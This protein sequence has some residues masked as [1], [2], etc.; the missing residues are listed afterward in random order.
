MNQPKLAEKLAVEVKV[1]VKTA[2][3][4]IK[5]IRDAMTEALVNGENIEIR[6]FGT[7]KIRNRVSYIFKN[8]R[9]GHKSEIKPRKT[10][11]FT[12]GDELKL[13]AN[14]GGKKKK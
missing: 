14:D 3:S 13:A 9:T 12:V 5:T 8:P 6:R 7:F 4:I 2:L 1:P 11:L 10:V